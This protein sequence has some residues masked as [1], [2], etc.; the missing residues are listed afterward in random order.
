VVGTPWGWVNTDRIFIFG[1]TN[2]LSSGSSAAV[3]KVNWQAISERFF[4][5]YVTCPKSRQTGFGHCCGQ[6]L[7]GHV[8]S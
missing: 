8:H 4:S 1:W 2:P 3:H 5:V 7:E 6:T